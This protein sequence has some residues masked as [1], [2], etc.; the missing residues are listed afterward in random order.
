MRWFQRHP[1]G[2]MPVSVIVFQLPAADK[3]AFFVEPECGVI[4]GTDFQEDSPRTLLAQQCDHFEEQQRSDFPAARGGINGQGVDAPPRP[5]RAGNGESRDPAQ[6]VS[7][8]FGN[9][10]DR[11]RRADQVAN[12]PL[13]KA[14]PGMDETDVLDTRDSGASAAQAARVCGGGCGRS[15]VTLHRRRL[16]CSFLAGLRHE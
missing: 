1:Q 14:L 6:Q 3:S 10:H 2:W 11:A 7:I 8:Q 13:P 4:V 15:A 9:A 5:R 16:R 12:A